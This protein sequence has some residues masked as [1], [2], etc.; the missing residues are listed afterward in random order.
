MPIRPIIFSSGVE[1]FFAIISTRS[2]HCLYA[3]LK[4]T[5]FYG[6][7]QITTLEKRRS[8]VWIELISI[9]IHLLN[10]SVRTYPK[11]GS[12]FSQGRS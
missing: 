11:Y 7:I 9:R 8:D 5:W 12:R 10:R 3:M 1:H 6:G 4:G 2:L